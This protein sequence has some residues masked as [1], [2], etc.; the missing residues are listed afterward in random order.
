MLTWTYSDWDE[1]PTNA[2]RF[3]GLLLH[4]REVGDYLGEFDSQATADVGVSHF[5]SVRHYLL[6]LREDRHRMEAKGCRIVSERLWCFGGRP[7]SAGETV[8]LPTDETA[9]AAQEARKVEPAKGESKRVRIARKD[10]LRFCELKRRIRA[11]IRRQGPHD[12]VAS[13]AWWVLANRVEFWKRSFRRRCFMCGEWF[14]TTTPWRREC[15]SCE[16]AGGY[17]GGTPHYR[18]DA[19]GS[20]DNIVR[21]YEEFR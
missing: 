21:T 17:G 5:L 1:Q 12:R 11:R 2:L 4:I 20:W 3:A 18:K 14:I 10:A 7:Q 16:S 13:I 8:C 9:D 15:A 6:A 19:G